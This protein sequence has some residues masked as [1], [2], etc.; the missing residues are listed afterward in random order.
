MIVTQ[1][2]A[3]NWL[4]SIA[5]LVTVI[6]FYAAHGMSL[7][8][9]G[10]SEKSWSP[11]WEVRGVQP[12]ACGSSSNSSLWLLLL[13]PLFPVIFIFQ[14]DLLSKLL[15][16]TTVLFWWCISGVYMLTDK[17]HFAWLLHSKSKL[18][19]CQLNAFYV[20]PRQWEMLIQH[21]YFPGMSPKS[22]S[23]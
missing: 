1:Y 4:F 18:V 20:K 13:V 5:L 6:W 8:T 14:T 21:F 16:I 23:L 12:V 3:N 17:Q 9:A 10:H 15:K 22:S 7:L 11:R 19:F 2:W